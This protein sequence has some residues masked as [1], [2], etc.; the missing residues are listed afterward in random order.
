MK[1]RRHGGASLVPE[2]PQTGL[3]S[4]EGVDTPGRV[5]QS[6][7][8]RGWWRGVAAFT[9]SSLMAPSHPRVT[10]RRLGWASAT[11]HVWVL[12]GFRSAQRTGSNG[13]RTPSRPPFAGLMGGAL[14]RV[15][16]AVW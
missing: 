8:V 10:R 14:T 1:P 9:R 12:P 15:D 7:I 5:L 11:P 3:V 16:V 6:H 4:A 2:Q 13:R